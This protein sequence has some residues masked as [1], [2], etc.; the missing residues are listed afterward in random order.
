[1]S[2]TEKF[3]G[4]TTTKKSKCMYVY[5]CVASAV[6]AL[7]SLLVGDVMYFFFDK[8]QS[9]ISAARS[10]KQP[11]R[12]H[13]YRGQCLEHRTTSFMGSIGAI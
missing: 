10:C 3:K 2:P 13:G 12:V 5:V 8:H 9:F 7:G 1:M 6:A 11:N 4:G